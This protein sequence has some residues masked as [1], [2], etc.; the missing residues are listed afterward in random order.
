MT[1]KLDIILDCDTK[2]EI[3][4]QFAIAYALKSPEINLLGVVSVQNTRRNGRKSVDIYHQEAEKILDL[5]GSKIKAFKGSTRPLGKKTNP[6]KSAGVDFIIKIVLRSKGKILVVCT[7]PAT[8]IANACMQ[9]PKI[10]PKCTF[11]WLGGFRN[12][13][14]ALRFRHKE[15]NL[16]GDKKAADLIFGLGI[17]LVFVPM[18]GVADHL[19]MQNHSFAEELRENGS[20]LNNYLADL[21]KS[22]WCRRYIYRVL[23]HALKRYWVLPDIAGVAVAKGL[24]VAK[25]RLTGW[26]VKSGK[27]I[28]KNSIKITQVNKIDSETIL[29]DF[30][31]LILK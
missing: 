22:N 10:I 19:V 13:Q 9:E 23:P 3:D 15:V 2:N 21:I 31:T 12:H 16:D 29:G 24:G 18:W 27:F 14:E 28:N 17:N 7:G 5:S 11:V 25:T 4:D 26:Q 1:T 20:P 8:D 6:E 30:K